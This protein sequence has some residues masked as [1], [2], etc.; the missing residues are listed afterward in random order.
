MVN[1][2]YQASGLNQQSQMFAMLLILKPFYLG[3]RLLYL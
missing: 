3:L 2:N 1:P